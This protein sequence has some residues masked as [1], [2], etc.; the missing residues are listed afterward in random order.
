MAILT[1]GEKLKQS[2]DISERIKGFLSDSEWKHIGF[3]ISNY[4]EIYCN[5]FKIKTFSFDTLNGEVV[6]LNF[7]S[8]DPEIYR[9]MYFDKGRV[10]AV[11]HFKKDNC[12][13]GMSTKSINVINTRP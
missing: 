11:W 2:K 8:E 5:N 6:R 3:K 1:K 10:H 4:L 7:Y 12:V 9:S 13:F